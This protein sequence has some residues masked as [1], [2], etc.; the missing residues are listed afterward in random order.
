M[1]KDLK[2]PIRYA[3]VGAGHIA[4]AA[5]LP[6]F[7]HAQEN[8]VLAAI[9]SSQPNKR[10]VLKKKYHV[11]TYSYEQY[12]QL[13]DSGKIDAVYIA[14]PNHLHAD[15]SVR[16]AQRGIHILCEKPMAVTDEECE[17]MVAAAE[18]NHVKLMIAYRLHFEKVNMEAVQLA[19]SGQLGDLRFFNSIFSLNVRPNNYRVKR[20]AGGGTVYDLGIYCINAARYLFRE[21]PTEV[22]A[23][24]ANNGEPRFQ[25]IDEMTSAVM[26][27]PNERLAQFT[28]SFGASDTSAYD[29]VGTKGSIHLEN[30]YEYQTERTLITMMGEE[31]NEK[32]FSKVDQFAPELIYFSDCLLDNKEPEPSGYEGWMDVRIILAIYQSALSGQPVPIKPLAIRKRPD[33]H[34][35]INRPPVKKPEVVGAAPA[36]Q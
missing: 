36:S 3:V 4:Q 19:K 16:A 31:K 30:A 34:Q 22:T 1:K 23:L 21:E 33:A 5:V 11:D 10:E 24:W 27:F 6:A 15:F 9:V 17:Q 2:S 26:K 12:D 8:S 7:E 35:I 14:L 32:K 20:D 18:E 13:L 29:L 28:S 25:E